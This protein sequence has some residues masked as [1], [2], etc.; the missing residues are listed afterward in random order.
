MDTI[1]V[2]YITEEGE[3]KEEELPW[4]DFEGAETFVD[5]HWAELSEEV[6][7]VSSG[8]MKSNLKSSDTERERI[9]IASIHGWPEYKT[10]WKN[11]CVSVFR[12]KMCTKVPHGFRRSANM[13]VYAEIS[14][15]RS[16]EA[17]LKQIAKDC[18][19]KAAAAAVAAAI[20]T[21]AAG[22]WPVFSNAFVA[23][24]MSQIGPDTNLVKFEV[25][26]ERGATGSWKPV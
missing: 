24:L 9:V 13:V 26:M 3:Y 23:C 10:E 1:K 25:D 6:E 17:G 19:T 8:V 21:G 20:A 7:L 12:K 14:Y 4:E 22:A 2:E 5:M 11:R 16:I 18:A 15:P